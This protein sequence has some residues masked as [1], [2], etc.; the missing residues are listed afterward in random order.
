M[1]RI[2]WLLLLYYITDR[3]QLGDTEPERRARLLERTAQAAEAGVD[4]IQLRE[5]DLPAAELEDLAVQAKQRL[6]GSKTRLLINSRVDIAIACGL[7]GVHLRGSPQE[8]AASEAR[9]IMVKAG[10]A[11]PW[12]G[13]S[14]HTAEEVLRAEA[15]GA[16][17]ALFGPVFE[18]DGEGGL[19][20]SALRAVCGQAK[21][22]KVMA[23]GGVTLENARVCI[24]AGA[25]GIAGI[26]LFQNETGASTA[27][28]RTL[29]SLG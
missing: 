26:R 18:K 2:H 28:V 9:T 15:H 24:A 14:C 22:I 6:A 21:S 4:W 5:K 17:F 3:R 13:V 20:A 25:A 16:D 8:L 1:Q 23:I 11:Q 12:V 10:M 29:R 27:L 7:D 19:G